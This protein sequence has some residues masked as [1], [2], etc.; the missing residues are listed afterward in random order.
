VVNDGAVGSAARM[1][2]VVRLK[3]RT[4]DMPRR[5]PPDAALRHKGIEDHAKVLRF[6][7][8]RENLKNTVT[9]RLESPQKLIVFLAGYIAMRRM[10]EV[11]TNHGAT[12][13]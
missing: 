4:T 5:Q 3:E 12:L 11:K 10:R 2:R 1:I 9:G 13:A 7:M 6:L 8:D